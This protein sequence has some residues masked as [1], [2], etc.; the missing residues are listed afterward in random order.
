MNEKDLK[1]DVYRSSGPGGQHANTTNSAV[2]LTYIPTGIIVTC[3]ESRCQFENK[4][5]A[6]EVLKGRIL[7]SKTEDYFSK[8]QLTRKEFVSLHD[9]FYP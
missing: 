5:K 9:N 6:L 4:A 8:Q 3:Q 1:I 2:R 7:K